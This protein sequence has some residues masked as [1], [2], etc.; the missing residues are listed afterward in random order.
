VRT[1]GS[2]V[3]RSFADFMGVKW[4][5]DVAA[6]IDGEPVTW[7][8]VH[9]QRTA[10]QQRRID[11]KRASQKQRVAAWVWVFYNNTDLFGGWFCYLVWIEDGQQR[12]VAVNFRGFD[13]GLAAS[14]MRAFP[15][16]VLPLGDPRD[17]FRQWM[18]LFAKKYPRKKPRKDPRKAGSAFVWYDRVNEMVER[19][20]SK[21]TPG[22]RTTRSGTKPERRMP[23][24]M[25]SRRK[26]RGG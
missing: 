19:I 20:P 23:E 9:A 10:M 7:A 17:S 21:Q 26:G 5:R 18:E 22:A 8:Q 12:D 11:W 14:L 2:I 15:M 1:T 25:G 3:M 6:Y 24:G 13:K 4:P 16:G